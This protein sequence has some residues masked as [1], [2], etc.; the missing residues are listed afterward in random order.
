MDFAKFVSLIQSK[1]L[2]F[3]SLIHLS[4]MDP[5]EGLPSPMNFKKETIVSIPEFIDS[6]S[7]Y[8]DKEY[9]LPKLVYKQ[10]QLEELHGNNVD[11]AINSLKEQSI[12]QRCQFFVNCWHMNNTDSDSQW[13]IYANDPSSLAIVTSYDRLCQS[14]KDSKDIY[15]SEITYYDPSKDQTPTNN[16][17]WDPILKKNAF[18]HEREFRLFHWDHTIKTESLVPPG[19]RVEI[20]LNILI[21]KIITSPKAGRN[22]HRLLKDGK[23]FGEGGKGFD[24]AEETDTVGFC[25]VKRRRGS[26]L[27]EIFLDAIEG[28]RAGENSGEEILFF[29][30]AIKCEQLSSRAFKNH[31]GTGGNGDE[32]CTQV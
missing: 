16:I 20:D 13:K 17:F 28:H 7:S 2:F 14:I 27:D 31:K 15:G 8:S 3:S 26:F 30:L 1:H 12:E 21:K 19:I 29:C 9:V 24:L 6:E 4:K 25:F 32:A 22:L 10:Y 11:N 5:W 18:S 23:L